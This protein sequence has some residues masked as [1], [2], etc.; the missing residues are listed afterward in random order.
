MTIRRQHELSPTVTV[1][2]CCLHRSRK[3]RDQENTESRAMKMPLWSNGEGVDFERPTKGQRDFIHDVNSRKNKMKLI[4]TLLL[5]SFYVFLGSLCTSLNL[6]MHDFDLTSEVQYMLNEPRRTH[7]AAIENNNTST[8]ATVWD[9]NFPFF[10]NIYIPPDDK[11]RWNTKQR[12]RA[13][14]IIQ[15]QVETV[16]KTDARDSFPAISLH[17]T[18]IGADDILTESWFDELCARNNITCHHTNHYEA[19]HELLTLQAMY[20]HCQANKT[21]RVGY[22][23]SKG[24]KIGA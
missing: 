3:Y 21:K 12:K 2:K 17:Y 6:Q 9:E 10:Y 11:S 5:A 15:E 14:S 4:I 24:D 1:V 8:T 18:T 16:G 13:L 19:G 20:E 7:G 22:I 23:H